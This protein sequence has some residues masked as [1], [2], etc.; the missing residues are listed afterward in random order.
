MEI[1]ILTVKRILS[2]TIIPILVSLKVEKK[3]LKTCWMT[4]NL[5]LVGMERLF[6]L[7]NPFLPNKN[8]E[9]G[10]AM[11]GFQFDKTLVSYVTKRNK[12]VIL[13]STMHDSAVTDADTGKQEIIIDYNK[14]KGGV[15]TCDKMCAAYSVS[16]ITRRWPLALFFIFMNIASINARM[17]LNFNTDSEPPRRKVF[18]KNLAM[19]LMRSHLESRAQIKSLPI[20]LY[21]S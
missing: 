13:L 12:G 5:S 16:R 18:Q 6:G 1:Q 17:I 3:I 8:K 20:D 9:V 10:S 11:Y 21:F 15:D 4:R 14:T 19:S 7:L 2:T